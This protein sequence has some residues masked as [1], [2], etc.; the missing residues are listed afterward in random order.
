MLGVR[1]AFFASI[2]FAASG[3]MLAGACGSSSSTSSTASGGGATCSKPGGAVS[4]AADKHCGSK[5]VTVDPN[6]CSEMGGAGGMGGGGGAGG[7][8]GAGGSAGG[9]GGSMGD[10]GPTNYGMEADDDDCKYHVV[11][12]STPVCENSGVTFTV[13]VTAKADGKPVTGASPI[14]EVFLNDKHPSPMTGSSSEGPPG[15]YQVGPIV[16]DAPGEWTVRFHLFETDC[17]TDDSPHGHAAFYID[18]P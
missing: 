12:T 7:K 1:S 3:V 10:Y 17:D 6:A 15:T 18:V 11:W 16:F 5:V 4:G 14:A 2:F 9:A 13:T 8:G